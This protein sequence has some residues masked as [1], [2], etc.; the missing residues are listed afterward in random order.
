MM[1]TARLHLISI[2]VRSVPN[3]IADP[4]RRRSNLLNHSVALTSDKLI[5]E[6]VLLLY[7]IVM[8]FRHHR[9]DDPCRFV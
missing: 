1:K 5:Q 4:A 7:D 9:P 3:P 6:R 2:T 8:V